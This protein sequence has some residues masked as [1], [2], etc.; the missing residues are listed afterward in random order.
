M[1]LEQI[2]VCQELTFLQSFLGWQPIKLGLLHNGKV[3]GVHWETI[4]AKGFPHGTFLLFWVDNKGGFRRQFISELLCHTK[5]LRCIW[6]YPAL[7]ALAESARSL[8]CAQD[9]GQAELDASHCHF[10]APPSCSVPH[11]P[12][13]RSQLRCGAAV[14]HYVSI[15]KEHSRSD[16][17]TGALHTAKSLQ[18]R[19]C[20][21]SVPPA[22]HGAAARGPALHAA[23]AHQPSER[24]VSHRKGCSNSSRRMP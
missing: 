15:R 12:N 13:M 14:W 3:R 11:R 17:L 4:Q 10:C 6:M 9:R 7:A 1:L 5:A 16:S 20:C 18:G 24:I 21:F 23:S 22:A 2:F 8:S 19:R